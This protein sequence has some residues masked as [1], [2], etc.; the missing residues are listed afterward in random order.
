MHHIV[1]GAGPA[2]VAA[3]RT[4][5]DLDPSAKITLLGNEPEPPYSRMAIPYLFHSARKI[6]ESIL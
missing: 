6:P 5:R 1:V 2:G 3:C 4:L